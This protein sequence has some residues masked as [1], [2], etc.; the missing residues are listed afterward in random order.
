M[1][2]V[3]RHLVS[4]FEATESKTLALHQ[5]TRVPSAGLIE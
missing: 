4:E 5:L 1:L 2:F 3:T